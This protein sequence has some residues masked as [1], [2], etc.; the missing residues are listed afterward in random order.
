M[1][2]ALTIFNAALS[3]LRTYQCLKQGRF[4]GI[5]WMLIAYFALFSIPLAFEGKMSHYRDYSGDWIEIT[6][7][8][9][10]IAIVYMVSFNAIFFVV[11]WLAWKLF[12]A[13]KQ[14]NWTLPIR[15]PY[16]SNLSMLYSILLV[17]G[18]IFYWYT[19]RGQ[20]YTDFVEYK[21]GNWGQVFLMAASPLITI[22]ALQKR[23]KMAV[24]L[25]LPFLYF[26]VH[27][28][29]RS[30]ALLSLIPVVIVYL[31]QFCTNRNITFE[32]KAKKAIML[33][34]FLIISIGL[35]TAIVVSKRNKV[36]VAS[37]DILP[38]M[39]MPYGSAIIMKLSDKYKVATGFDSLSL[40]AAN[41]ANPF[42]KL[43]GMAAPGIEDTPAV[44]AALWDGYPPW[45]DTYYHYPTLWYGDAY[46]S[47]RYYG[48]WLAALWAIVLVLW[49][50][51]LTH[52]KL[53]FAILLPYFTWHAYMLVRGAIAGAAVPFSYAAYVSIIVALLGGVGSFMYYVRANRL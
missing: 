25:C 22:F 52:S 51:I 27:L 5:V 47:F 14:S 53:L 48:L 36:E 15:I 45:S 17:V 26:A 11:E 41:F 2:I 44:M 32:E 37:H 21:G 8:D 6:P 9:F 39:G 34:G 3:L 7:A 42:R 29:V 24:V 46:V 31:L 20:N 33:V 28:H 16:L 23:Y 19:T 12:G 30:F 13:T 49:E 1:Y 43:V 50:R 10:H 38:D 40:Y 18:T 35:S 4:M